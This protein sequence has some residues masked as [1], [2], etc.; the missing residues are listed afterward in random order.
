MTN[1]IT[2]VFSK[3]ANT[4]LNVSLVDGGSKLDHAFGPNS[5]A[6]CATTAYIE[7]QCHWYLF[8]SAD[9]ATF[10]Q[11]SVRLCVENMST[12][13]WTDFDKFLEGWGADQRTI[14]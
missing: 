7:E 1:S 11:R 5:V 6:P 2:T 8:S 10:S 14:D 13:S 3:T 4:G 9:E 12:K